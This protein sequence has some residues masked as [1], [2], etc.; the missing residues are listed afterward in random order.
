MNW[1]YYFKRGVNPTSWES[2]TVIAVYFFNLRALAIFTAALCGKFCNYSTLLTRNP[3]F[4]EVEWWVQ[5]VSGLISPSN[6]PY[7]S[8]DLHYLIRCSPGALLLEGQQ[9]QQQHL[10]TCYKCRVSGCTPDLLSHLNKLPRGPVFPSI[11]VWEA[12]SQSA[13]TL[14]QLCENVP[15]FQWW[16]LDTQRQ[17]NIPAG[18]PK[19]C[20]E[21][22]WAQYSLENRK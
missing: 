9:Q 16:L 4:R 17:E 1:S 3:N 6:T 8:I 13:V 11:L 12:P 18:F 14:S 21:E 2:S 22:S 15:C 10:D 5:D 20:S 19:Q 7:Q